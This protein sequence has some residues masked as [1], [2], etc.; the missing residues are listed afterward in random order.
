[1]T[2]SP[3][4][5]RLLLEDRL[6][7]ALA[8]AKRHGTCLAVCYI[9]LDEFKHINDT[10]GHSAGDALLRHVA[11][12]LQSS[13][14]EIDTVARQGGDEFILLLP[15]LTGPS[16]A[17]DI[18]ERV[19]TGLRQPVVID[20]QTLV[21][22]ASIGMSLYP[23]PAETASG[24]L[25][26]ADLALYTAKRA[27]RD[28]MQRFDSALGEQM[29]QRITLE[30]ELRFALAREQLTIEYQPL[31]SAEMK[32]EG[33]EALLRWSHPTL[34]R[35]DPGLFVPIAEQS[36]FIVPIG[37]WVLREACQ[38]ALEWNLRSPH[39]IRVFV[40]V[41]GVQLGLASFPSAVSEALAQT[42]LEASLL[43]IEIT[44]GWI[45]SDPE[46]ATPKLQALR[47][48]GVRISIDDFG[49]GHASFTYLQQLPIDTVKIDR[50]FVSCLNG[51]TKQS[52]IVRAI[53]ALAEELGLCTVAEGIE[54][55]PQLNELLTTQCEL[56]Q[57][58]LFSKPLHSASASLLLPEPPAGD[59]PLPQPLHELADLAFPLAGLA[60]AVAQPD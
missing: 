29:Q 44:E 20:H 19:L 39:P 13:L 43:E 34:G 28:R 36:G 30:R 10:L 14:R 26:H 17:E 12:V 47:A 1:M 38:Q 56:F 5:N 16:E 51:T 31:Y 4:F 53:I 40:N 57:G 54:T 35:I 2:T 24:L 22:A 18:C 23:S 49:S 41:S 8:N 48:L 42:G 15:D 52:A 21:P 25:Q 9:D 55:M 33:F 27:G 32:L 3:A 7:Q 50:S 11:T 37:E 6:N 58:F 46:T 45:I 59:I 60:E